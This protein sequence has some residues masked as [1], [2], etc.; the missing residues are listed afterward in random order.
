MALGGE[1]KRFI[2]EEIKRQNEPMHDILRKLHE[3]QLSFWSNGSGRVP[4]FFQNRMKTDDDRYHALKEETS[5]QSILLEDVKTFMTE[6]RTIREERTKAEA[7]RQ[8]RHARYWTVAKVVG[9]LLVS[10]LLWGAKETYP[11]V[12]I[13]VD[14]YLRAHPYVTEQL[15]NR[16]MSVPD[17][18]YAERQ[19]SA[20]LPQSYVAR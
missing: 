13:L 15:K 18:V 9:G 17:S 4:G 2:V 20:D 10:A 12:K 3:W 1:Q 6:I 5:S 7:E 8:K 11:V 19:K 16:A 14:D